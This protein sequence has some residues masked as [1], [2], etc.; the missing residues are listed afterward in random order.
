MTQ[1]QAIAQLRE[2]TNCSD[3]SAKKYLKSNNWDLHSA[4]NHYLSSHPDT[5]RADGDKI[6]KIFNK[7]AEKDEIPIEG[8]IKYLEDIHLGLEEIGVLGLAMELGAPTQGVF[9]RSGFVGGWKALGINSL[10]GMIEHAAT[11]TPALLKPSSTPTEL[12]KKTYLHTFTFAL[13]PPA[14]T[15]PLESALVFW[16]LLLSHRFKRLPQWK[17]FLLEKGKAISRDVWNLLLDFSETVNY[18][19]SN[20]DEMEAWPVVIDNFVAWVKEKER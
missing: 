12:F 10:Q 15:L 7:Y 17:E 1:R 9:T 16:D 18:D 11:L 5:L 13:S 4:L 19:L 8:T 3:S 6:D 14:R 2:W 20:Y